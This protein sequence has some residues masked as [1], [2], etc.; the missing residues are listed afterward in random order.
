MLTAEK[1]MGILRAN[2][3]RIKEFGVKQIGLFG[4]FARGAGTESS[5]ID[6]LVEFE[7]GAK[8]FDNYMGLKLFLEDLFGHPVDL[9]IKSGLREELKPFILS[10]TKYVQGL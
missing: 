9:V 1:I 7:P 6:I 5:D 3:E 10:D 4:S 8:T 2:A